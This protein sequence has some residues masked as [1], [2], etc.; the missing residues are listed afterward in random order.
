[1]FELVQNLFSESFVPHGHCYL[2]K[3][4]LVWLNVVSDS[5]IFLAY[6]S[7]PLQ[8]LYIV[9]KRGDIPFD[10]IFFLFGSF[11][12]AC[13]SG[14]LMD[15]WTLWHPTY[16]LSSL[17]KS[18]IAGISI[19]TAIVLV[20]LIPKILALPSPALITEANQKLAAEVLERQE[21]ENA[22]RRSQQM[23]QL[24]IDTFPQ[25]IFWKDQNS[26][27]LGCNKQFAHDAG[28]NTTDEIVGLDDFSMSWR[29]IAPLYQTN[30]RQLMVTKIPKLNR[31]E[32]RADDAGN[33]TWIRVNMIPLQNE[34][35]EVIGLLGSYEDIT[36][37]KQA[38]AE[39]RQAKEAAEVSL[40]NF[41]QAQNQLI[42][43]EKM[44]SLGQL[45]AGVAHEINNPVNFIHGNLNYIN[46]YTKEL[47]DLVELYQQHYPQPVAAVRDRFEEID[48]DFLTIDLPKVVSSM[49]MGAERIR[50]I[51]LSLRNFSRLDQAEM[52]SVCIH[53]GIDS[54]LLILQHR[55]KAT[56]DRPEVKLIKNYGNLPLVECYAGQLNQVFMNILTNA[57]DALE[58]A[59]SRPSAFSPQPLPLPNSS[60]IIIST[61]VVDDKYVLIRIRDNGVGMPEAVR[62]R[63]FD[64]F[65]TTK[66]VGKGTGLGLSISY[67]IVV[68]KHGGSLECVSTVG[69]GTEFRIQIPIQPGAIAIS[70]STVPVAA[71]AKSKS[72]NEPTTPTPDHQREARKPQ[73][74]H[75][76]AAE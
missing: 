67:Q 68:E 21:I 24:V 40:A 64:P 76:F 18:L 22:L 56:A 33:L 32:H 60:T 43:A 75:H 71:D 9:K 53:E 74:A 45:V 35:N 38:E 5:I 8:L 55:F 48:L 44:S 1:M 4:A 36:E 61:L 73:P 27:Y 69:Q 62:S 15:V 3:P 49:Q 17:L 72:S 54:T 58:E 65:F 2:W 52:K 37:Y 10:W 31:E 42:Q 25:R 19:S 6:Y 14:H 57:L 66:P 59:E 47:L 7:I 41:Q 28:F 50:Q 11:I 39:I 29:E 20:T 12:V 34:N 63:L 13:G 16:W 51:V 70:N 23:F 46:S 30:D 26:R